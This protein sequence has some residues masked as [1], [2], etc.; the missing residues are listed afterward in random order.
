MI[1]PLGD[2]PATGALVGWVDKELLM[3]GGIYNFCLVPARLDAHSRFPPYNKIKQLQ[4]I[5]SLLSD[6]IP[7]SAAPL[8]PTQRCSLFLGSET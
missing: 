7:A 1:F 4:D 8:R 2:Q 5:S 6:E 3:V